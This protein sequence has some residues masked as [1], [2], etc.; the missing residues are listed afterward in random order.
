[1]SVRSRLLD[2]LRAG[3]S[4]IHHILIVADQAHLPLK[5][6][7]PMVLRLCELVQ[8]LLPGSRVT[9]ASLGWVVKLRVISQIVVESAFVT[10]RLIHLLETSSGVGDV[11][12]ATTTIIGIVNW[13]RVN[14][15]D[16]FSG[17]LLRGN[18]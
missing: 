14:V 1:V 17:S 13:L 15:G 7:V 18:E 2:G 10:S 12:I 6:A 11:G 3:K 4:I 8:L 16:C 5:S 9:L